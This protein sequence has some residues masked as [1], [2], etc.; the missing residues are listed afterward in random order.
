MINTCFVSVM[1]LDLP[2]SA[3]TLNTSS[4]PR[5]LDTYA[6]IYT[7]DAAKCDQPACSDTIASNSHSTRSSH[8]AGSVKSAI[9]N[10]DSAL[11]NSVDGYRL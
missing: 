11:K 6:S 10:P 8:C 2:I 9:S 1:C 3:L 5:P 7:S 4:A